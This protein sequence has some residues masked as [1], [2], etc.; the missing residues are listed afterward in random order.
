MMAVRHDESRRRRAARRRSRFGSKSMDMVIARVPQGATAQSRASVLHS[1]WL[2]C[3]HNDGPMSPKSGL[4]FHA[5]RLLESGAV[6]AEVEERPRTKAEG[7]GKDRC[8]ELLDARIVFLHRVVEKAA[9]GRELVLDIGKVVL[10]LL[11]IGIGLEVRIV[12][13]KREQLPQG[14][15]QRVLGGDPLFDSGRRKGGIARLDH[16]FESSALVRGVTFDGFDQIR[17]EI[18]AL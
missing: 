4:K 8:R 1:G 6:L 9:G 15:R 2:R 11:K 16:G 17:N 3:A 5:R 10:Q 14:P 18:V 7:P 13:R 12:L